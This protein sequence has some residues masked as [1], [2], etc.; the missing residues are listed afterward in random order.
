MTLRSIADNNIP[1]AKMQ[2]V[3]I[4]R[5]YE[6]GDIMDSVLRVYKKHYRD[7]K[8]F[9]PNLKG[10]SVYDTCCNVFAFVKKHIRYVKDPSDN[11]WVKTPS[12]LWKDKTGDCK[13]YSVF[14]GSVLKCLG[15]PFLFRFVSFDRSNALPS[16]VYIVV[17]HNGKEIIID[18]V[19]NDFDTQAAYAFKHD[20]MQGLYELSGVPEVSGGAGT[21]LFG[22]QR[23]AALVA[24]LPQLAANFVYL[25]IPEGSV[26]FW[27]S[28][29]QNFIGKVPNIVYEKRKMA[30]T[31]ANDWTDW[32]GWDERD[33]M[34]TLRGHVENLLGKNAEIWWHDVLRGKYGITGIGDVL[35]TATGLLSTANPIWGATADIAA[36]FISKIFGGADIQWKVPLQNFTPQESDWTGFY[37]TNLNPVAIIKSKATLG[38]QPANSSTVYQSAEPLPTTPLP[39]YDSA[40][41]QVQINPATGQPTTTAGIASNTTMNMILT[42]GLF[43]GAAYFLFKKKKTS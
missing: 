26:V 19:L 34:Q 8:E 2:Q 43:A 16:H 14:I 29:G 4:N 41:N 20:Y 37:N 40:G 33:F 24:A 25:F 7:V 22:A 1:R 3:L 39:V 35:N 17:P 36:S 11:Q 28:Y 30:W 32:A 42:A 21:A 31:V 10:Q 18:A 6:I 12:R 13:S 38:V 5:D 15:V 9:A 27:S 23:K